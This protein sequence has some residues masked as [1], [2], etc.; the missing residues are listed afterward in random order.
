MQIMYAV[1]GSRRLPEVTLDHLPGYADSRPVRI[2]NG[3][4]EQTQHD[5]L[6]R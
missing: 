6:A 5:V 2:G 1:D 4:V 3:A